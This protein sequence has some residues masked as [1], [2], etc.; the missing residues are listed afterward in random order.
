MADP[1]KIERL[2][3]VVFYTLLGITLVAILGI[4]FLAW[5]MS[6]GHGIGRTG[7]LLRNIDLACTTYLNDW[8]TYPLGDETILVR[9]LTTETTQSGKPPLGPYMSF[10]DDQ[11][12]RKKTLILDGW[13]N[14]IRY[15]CPGK[16]A[17]GRFDV[18]S[19]GPDGVDDTDDD[20]GN[21]ED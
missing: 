20:I 16:R 15:R 1:K 14:T 4:V 6:G 7:I 13:G 19:A 2:L 18:W 12:N 11:L 5:M 9:S 21:W 17:S 3:K 8:G 10:S